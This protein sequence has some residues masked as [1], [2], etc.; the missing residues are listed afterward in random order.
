MLL[1]IDVKESALDKFMNMLNSFKSEV[2]IIDRGDEESHLSP[3]EV[4]DNIAAAVREL[5]LVLEGKLKA[6]PIE[7][8]LNEL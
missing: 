1:T 6:K 4:K 3:S 8:L 7:E 2:K 5:N